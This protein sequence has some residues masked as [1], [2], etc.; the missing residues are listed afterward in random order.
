MTTHREQSTQILKW[1][2]EG[3]EVE[4]KTVGFNEWWTFKLVDPQTSHD[5]LVNGI[6]CDDLEFR[7]KPLAIL[8]NGEV[9][10]LPLT[11]FDDIPDGDNLFS[12]DFTIHGNVGAYIYKA[13]APSPLLLRLLNRGLLYKTPSGANQRACAMLKTFPAP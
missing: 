4:A 3:L 1:L 11:N 8:V 5:I 7:K 9:C 2:S 10:E 6:T 13:A 12:V